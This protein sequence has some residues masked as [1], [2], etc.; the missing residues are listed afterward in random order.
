MKLP[1][2]NEERAR[3]LADAW[4]SPDAIG[5]LDAIKAQHLVIKG[6]QVLCGNADKDIQQLGM[7]LFTVAA[8]LLPAAEST[9][10]QGSEQD[11]LD[12]LAARMK[13]LGHTDYEVR[14][15]IVYWRGQDIGSVLYLNSRSMEQLADILDRA[16]KAG[17]DGA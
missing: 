8:W 13:Y 7:A 2:S 15:Q 14:G 3:K 1:A 9:A 16:R 6:A 12:V 11:D 17:E 10:Q 5:Q 4:L